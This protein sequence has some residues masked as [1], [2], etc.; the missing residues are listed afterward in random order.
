MESTYNK[1]LAELSDELEV[2]Q[3][4]DLNAEADANLITFN[5][6]AEPNSSVN[7]RALIDFLTG[8]RDLFQQK[9]NSTKMV[10][11]SWYDEQSDQLR[12]S[13]VS[14]KHAPLPF[15][16]KIKHCELNEFVK[17]TISKNSG[18]FSEPAQLNV[19][20]SDI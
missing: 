4:N 11:Y 13:A 9:T 5:L 19:W 15:R 18:L 2:I 10:F 8:C 7:E 14:K 6:P 3:S 20:Q 17:E 12:I 16:C 1:W